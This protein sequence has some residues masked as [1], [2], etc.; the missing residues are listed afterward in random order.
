MPGP[1]H[2]DAHADA[3]DRGRPQ[4]P[5]VLWARLEDLG[6]L[7]PGV[8]VLELGAGT[9]QATG[10][11][12]DAGAAVTAIEPGPALA[13][14]LRRRV[15]A[16]AVHLCTAESMHVPSAAF[17]LAVAATSVHWLDLGVVLPKVHRALVPGG[18]LAVWRTAYGDPAGPVTP[19]RERVRHI[20]ARRGP[21]AARPGPGELDTGAW[22]D[23][24]TATG[25]F[26]VRHVEE[27]R[28]SVELS[29]DQ[30]RDLFTTFSDWHRDEVAEAARTVDDLGGRV[31]EHYLTPLIVLDRAGPMV[32]VTD[33]TRTAR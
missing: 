9:G 12:L 2:F 23:R 3:Y 15:P 6:V 7:R 19:F 17:D 4:Y 8:R 27:F 10:P 28:W 18:H 11:L 5:A 1:Q 33:T 32:A 29:T 26:V 16:A 13:A 20:S 22:V 14:L 24:L 21:A 30:V 25:H 31:V